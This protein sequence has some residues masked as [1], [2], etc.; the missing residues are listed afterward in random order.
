MNSSLGVA[1]D[2]RESGKR[3]F[4]FDTKNG[5]STD[6]VAMRNLWCPPVFVT[7]CEYRVGLG[8]LACF[9]RDFLCFPCVIKLVVTAVSDIIL[10]YYQLF[11][12]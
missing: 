10:S 4:D 7:S 9:F 11:I 2:G 6:I 3:E 12:L 5:I 1:D 8:T